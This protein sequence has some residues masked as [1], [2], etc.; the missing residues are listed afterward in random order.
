MIETS[1]FCVRKKGCT[2]FPHTK[3]KKEKCKNIWE[4]W[5]GYTRIAYYV[6]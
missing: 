6:S 1:A 5:D 2:A 4:Q 3:K